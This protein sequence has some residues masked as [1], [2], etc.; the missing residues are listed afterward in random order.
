MRTP[1]INFQKLMEGVLLFVYFYLSREAGYFKSYL[2]LS[3]ISFNEGFE[4]LPGV[5]RGVR[6]IACMFGI[7]HAITNI[8]G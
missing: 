1:S 3:K 7:E 5:I 4:S 2:P 8:W 6:S